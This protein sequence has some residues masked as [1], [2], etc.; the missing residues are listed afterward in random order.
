V[1]EEQRLLQLEKKRGKN[2]QY[3]LNNGLE[4][5]RQFLFTTGQFKK[6]L[7]FA[8]ARTPHILSFRDKS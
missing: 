4:E 6:E 2:T 1:L 5:I 3:M 7:S 8:L